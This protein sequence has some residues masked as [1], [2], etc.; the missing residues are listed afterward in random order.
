MAEARSSIIRRWRDLAGKMPLTNFALETEWAAA[1][2]EFASAA[3]RGSFRGEAMALRRYRKAEARLKK[4]TNTVA[5]KKVTKKKATK[6]A[7]KKTPK[8]PGRA[9]VKKKAAKK[10]AGK[11]AAGKKVKKGKGAKNVDPSP[12]QG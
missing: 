9:G 5:K 1:R 6:K 2:E 11:K 8:K 3:S 7:A 12:P 4:G 10:V